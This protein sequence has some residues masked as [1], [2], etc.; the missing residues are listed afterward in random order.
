MSADNFLG[1]YKVNNRKYIGRS[2]WSECER[3]DCKACESR[4]IFT[5]KSMGEAVEIAENALCDPNEVYEY[6]YRFLNP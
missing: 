4:V 5:A 1:I 2:C 3:P 6:G